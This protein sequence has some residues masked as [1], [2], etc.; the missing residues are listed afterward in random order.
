MF[1]FIKPVFE[2]CIP[3]YVVLAPDLVLFLMCIKIL[4]CQHHLTP[5]NLKKD[6]RRKGEGGRSNMDMY[7]LLCREFMNQ[8]QLTLMVM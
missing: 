8:N 5:L 3:L 7:N 1:I 6:K 2:T 4:G